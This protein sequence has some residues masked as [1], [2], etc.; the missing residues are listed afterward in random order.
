VSTSLLQLNLEY[1]PRTGRFMSAEALAHID[2]RSPDLGSG[3]S[4][5]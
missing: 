1:L 5:P 4:R 3:D 2:P